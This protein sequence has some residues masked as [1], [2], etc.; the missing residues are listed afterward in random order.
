MQISFSRMQISF[1]RMQI[2]FS[3]MQISFSRMQISFSHFSRLPTGCKFHSVSRQPDANCI[4]LAAIKYK[5]PK[6]INSLHTAGNQL[7]EICIQLADSR[8]QIW[9]K[10]TASTLSSC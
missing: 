10:L 3:R 6:F 1:S 4:W 5:I 8:M 9:Q 7:N 2:S